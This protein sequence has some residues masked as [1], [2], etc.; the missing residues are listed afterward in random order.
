[1]DEFISRCLKLRATALKENDSGVK[2]A[3]GVDAS[4]TDPKEK[5]SSDEGVESSKSRQGSSEPVESPVVVNGTADGGDHCVDGKGS[6][7]QPTN[8]RHLSFFLKY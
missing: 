4:E 6:R 8:F 5:S 1:M 3:N 2:L 7:F